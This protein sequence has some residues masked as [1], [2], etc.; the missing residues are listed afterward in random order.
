M[1]KSWLRA[2]LFLVASLLVNLLLFLS[3]PL[4]SQLS[5]DKR[6][7]DF[8]DYF[9]FRNL[10]HV[11]PKEPPPQPRN[12]DPPTPRKMPPM[13]APVSTRMP[14]QPAQMNRPRP[15]Q[16]PSFQ[17]AP[18]ELSMGVATFTPVGPPQT[19]FDL[20]AV[21]TQPQLFTRINPVYPY[22]ARQK[23]LEGV[24]IVKFLVGADGRVSRQTVVEAHPPEVFDQAAL[25]AVGMWNFHP[26]QLDGEA[27]ATW[28]TVPIRFKMNP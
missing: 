3:I 17:P 24:V 5:V 2:K 9:S 10:T 27:V 16:L 19:E 13:P 11:R 22:A 12:L 26:A 15:L 28:M 14:Q 7:A 1:M 21:D 6:Q 8:S 20:S 25:E 18:K 4:L 23:N